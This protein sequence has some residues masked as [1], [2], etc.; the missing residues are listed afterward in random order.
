MYF[1]IHFELSLHLKLALRYEETENDEQQN[2]SYHVLLQVQFLGPEA[3]GLVR[4]H[5]WVL[6]L[7]LAAASQQ[8]TEE[9]SEQH[10]AVSTTTLCVQPLAAET[11]GTWLALYLPR[12]NN[13]ATL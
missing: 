6:S 10:D 9:P 4:R 11:G 12:F 5:R 1:W 13:A 7:T 8:K 3:N 2:K